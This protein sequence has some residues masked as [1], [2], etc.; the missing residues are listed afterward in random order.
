MNKIRF[1]LYHLRK[2]CIHRTEIK[3]A[4][5]TNVRKQLEKKISKFGNPCE[6]IRITHKN[7][8]NEVLLHEVHIKGIIS[9][10]KLVNLPSMKHRSQKI[11]W[12][13]LIHP[14]KKTNPE[15]YSARASQ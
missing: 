14:P 2:C 1:P 5:K 12:R 8:P 15:E 3:N 13:G 6:I 9:D 10:R 11:R 7:I 4:R